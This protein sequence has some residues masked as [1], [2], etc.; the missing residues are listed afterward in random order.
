MDNLDKLSQF[1]VSTHSR[2]LQQRR[3]NTLGFFLPLGVALFFLADVLLYSFSLPS[4]F[5]LILPLIVVCFML[6]SLG[7]DK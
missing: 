1:I 2:A 7:H 3:M 6:N 5:A 4:V